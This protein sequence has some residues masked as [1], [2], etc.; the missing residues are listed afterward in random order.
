MLYPRCFYIFL[1]QSY[2]DGFNTICA[3]GKSDPVSIAIKHPDEVLEIVTELRRKSR[4]AESD[5]SILFLTADLAK[6]ERDAASVLGDLQTADFAAGNGEQGAGQRQV[7]GVSFAVRGIA[8]R[9]TE[10]VGLCFEFTDRPGNQ[11]DAYM[12]DPALWI[13]IGVICGSDKGQGCAAIFIPEAVLCVADDADVAAV[14]PW[15]TDEAQG[16][17]VVGDLRAQNSPVGN[18]IE[19]VS[20]LGGDIRQHESELWDKFL[21]FGQLVPVNGQIVLD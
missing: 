19:C 12:V 14:A 10:A 9:M 16:N 20:G 1:F 17:H 15:E 4:L 8:N 2:A 5:H 3:D 21:F 18:L 13:R 7:A 6:T 11:T